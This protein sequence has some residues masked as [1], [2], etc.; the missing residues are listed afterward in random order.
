MKLAAAVVVAAGMALTGC[1]GGHGT[2]R[3]VELTVRHSRFSL[4]ELH[5]RPGETIRF[6]LRNTDPIPHELIVGDQSVQDVHE[7][8]TE[9]HHGD[10]PGEV[11]VA[12]GATAVTT[13]RFGSAGRLLFGC[14]LPGHWDY[15]MRGTITV[16]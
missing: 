9:A 10:R 12:P 16:R 13:Y 4:D 3:T 15:G 11:S 2:E 1:A 14:H 8:G 5:V 6:V 7:A